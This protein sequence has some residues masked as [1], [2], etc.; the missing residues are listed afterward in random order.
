M[1]GIAAKSWQPLAA[2]AGRDYVWLEAARSRYESTAARVGRAGR[3]SF[4][5][6]EG[7]DLGWKYGLHAGCTLHFLLE[8]APA[9]RQD[10]LPLTQNCEGVFC[11]PV[12]TGRAALGWQLGLALTALRPLVLLRPFFLFERGVGCTG[13]EL[14]VPLADTRR[15]GRLLE[16]G[17][18]GTELQG[19]EV[20][21]R[22]RLKT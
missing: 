4:F 5:A 3:V 19:E 22:E 16:A 1:E 9:P 11:I 21:L 20:V 15:L 6:R 8:D 14:R 17:M 2:A 18:A 13:P 7:C 10:W 12:K